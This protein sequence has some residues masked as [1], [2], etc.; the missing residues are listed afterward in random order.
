M[1]S[2]ALF[3]RLLLR[4]AVA[5]PLGTLVVC[6]AIKQPQWPTIHPSAVFDYDT[7]RVLATFGFSLSAPFMAA[8]GA[9]RYV[10]DLVAAD[11]EQSALRGG[12]F[13]CVVVGL[14]GV[15]AVPWHVSHPV[16][17]AFAVTFFLAA[18]LDIV[19]QHVAATR[20]RSAAGGSDSC[21]VPKAAARLLALMLCMASV[22]GQV[23]QN[24]PLM[25]VGECGFA[26]MYLTVLGIEERELER[27]GVQL[28]W[29]TSSS[30]RPTDAALLHDS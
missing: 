3:R 27:V 16:H 22:G 30:G 19:L 2:A 17:T 23:T 5:L 11:G 25:G 28:S 6:Y 24:H 21:E 18:A 13:F 14:L 10:R 7:P 12:V 15:A 1:S 29:H 20:R 26:V 4:T 8:F 9:V